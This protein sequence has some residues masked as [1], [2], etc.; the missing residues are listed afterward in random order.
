[1]LSEKCKLQISVL[2]VGPLVYIKAFAID[3]YICLEMSGMIS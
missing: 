2:Y 3:T 1:M